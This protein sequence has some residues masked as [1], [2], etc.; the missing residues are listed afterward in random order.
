MFQDLTIANIRPEGR[1]GVAITLAGTEAMEWT[2]GQYLT[3]RA[4]V[5]GKDIRRSYSIASLPGAPLTVGIK[6]VEGGAFSTFAQGLHAGDGIKVMP[7][8]GRFVLRD[9]QRIVLIA[10]GSGI[11]PM[12]AIAGAALARGAEV[13]LICGNRDSGSIMFRAALDSLK[14]RYMGRFTLIHVLSREDQDVALLNGRI[15]GDKLRAMARAG[16]VDP[17][18]ADG[19]FLCG[20]GAMIDDVSLALTA[21]GVT[22]DRVHSERFH[23]KKDGPRPARSATSRSATAL[24]AAAE[25]VAVDVVLD[26]LTR[27][28]EVGAGDDTVLD[29]AERQG[30]ELPYSCRGGMCCTCRCKVTKGT[31]EMAVNYSLEPWELTAGFVLACQARPTSETLVLDFDAA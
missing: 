8:E 3:L 14:D 15:T 30:L 5:D 24:A 1:D 16:A 29:A 28:F 10:A 23:S 31:A 6:R 17:N 2:P 22:P 7:P 13:A 4:R 25:A 20:P 9:E 26:G 19:V 27:R 12:V 18:R 21:I 11:T